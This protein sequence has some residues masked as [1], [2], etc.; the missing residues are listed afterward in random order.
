MANLVVIYWRDIP[1]QVNAQAGRKRAQAIL[2]NR[3]QLA[4]D[5]AAMVAGLKTAQDYIGE[6]RRE[7]TPCSDDLETEAATEAARL[8]AE[9]PSERV[10]ALVDR[11][12]LEASD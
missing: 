6:W 2:P 10:N 9:Y 1:A 4:I 12:G 8:D 3:F 11:G 7:S 5:R